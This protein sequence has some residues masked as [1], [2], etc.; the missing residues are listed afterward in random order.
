M[1]VVSR[2]PEEGDS[3]AIVLLAEVV[4]TTVLLLPSEETRLVSV[5]A[6]VVV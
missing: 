5:V 2:E 6:K 4:K 1:K 3:R